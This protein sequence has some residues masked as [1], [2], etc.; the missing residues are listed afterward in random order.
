MTSFDNPADLDAMP[1]LGLNP[2]SVS[3]IAK[4]AG[5]SLFGSTIGIGLKYAFTA[6]AA[7]GLG[8][9]AYGLLT[10]ALTIVNL[11]GLIALLGLDQ[12]ALRYI[13][14][15]RGISDE[16]GERGTVILT[17]VIVGCSSVSLAVLVFF[18]AD[19]IASSF[20]GSDGELA[21]LLRTLALSIPLFAAL[22]L[23]GAVTNAQKKMQYRAIATHICQP[24]FALVMFASLLFLGWRLY[25]A[26][27]AYLLSALIAAGIASY[28]VR[29]YF[30]GGSLAQIAP[31]YELQSLTL[32]SLPLFLLNILRQTTNRLEIYVLG[33]LQVA[34]AVGIFDVAAR[35]AALSTVA[36]NSLNAISAPMISDLYNRGQKAELDG[37][38]KVVTRWSILFS[39][40]S[41]IITWLFAE[42]ILTLLGCDFTV[43]AV[44]LIILSLGQ[45]VNGATGP[46]GITL[47]MSGYPGLNF[48][49]SIAMLAC[50]LLLD[51]WLIPKSG[52]IG[53]AMGST[54]SLVLFNLLK[55][56]QVRF[57]LGLNPY[58]QRSAKP[59]VA[60]LASAI[61]TRVLRPV[62]FSNPHAWTIIL[63]PV[64]FVVM[65]IS[66]LLVL[67]IENE[68]R[69]VIKRG[70]RR[71]V[72]DILKSTHL[73]EL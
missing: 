4:G 52:L 72:F 23:F 45:F 66:M 12:G 19:P 68:E 58:D 57:I 33:L 16:S 15:Y 32:F 7:R 18:L 56:L 20:A 22:T 39:T 5:I 14:M 30:V 43:G 44:A 38:L 51:L 62:L 46:V 21:G 36:L 1:P 2:S 42:S 26:V 24:L 25:G 29:A 31:R 40:P 9:H 63:G 53:A 27:V 17:T 59:L 70:T 10:L 61:V 50:N 54:L 34:E 11:L 60:G 47:N 48:V 65:Y 69:L 8:A 67:G 6:I 28:F 73:A 3:T 49:N 37:L 64:V 41:L 71:C 35:T 13:A 55:L